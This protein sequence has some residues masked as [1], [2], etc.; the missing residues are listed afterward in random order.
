MRLFVSH[1]DMEWRR[2]K[3]GDVK[4]LEGIYRSHIKSLINYGLRV[5]PDLNLVKDSIQDLF[6]E[7]WRNRENLADTDQPKYY[8]FRALRNKLSRAA[9]RQSFISEAEMQL[10]SNDLLTNPIELE[11]LAREQ[12]IQTRKTLQQL[13]DKL[14]RRQQEVIYLRFYHNFPYEII[15]STMNMNYQSV[16]NLVQRAL[17]TLRQAYFPATSPDPGKKV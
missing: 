10:S 9:T 7:L 12:E 11:I 17:K 15:A 3:N 6:M 4:A 13:L 5:T 1:D 8:L 2:F 14:P 16:L